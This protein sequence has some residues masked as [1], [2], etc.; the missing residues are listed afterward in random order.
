M[1]VRYLYQLPMEGL[2]ILCILLT[3]H[4]MSYVHHFILINTFKPVDSYLR[5]SFSI[6]VCAHNEL[7]NLKRLIPSILSQE[8]NDF[9]AIIILDRC[10]DNSLS[11]LENIQKNHS[12]LKVIEVHDLPKQYNGKKYGLSK[13]IKTATK[14]WIL[15]TDADCLPRSENWIRAFA[16]Q[17]SPE[18]EIILGV[19]PYNKRPGL[20]NHF[21]QYETLTTAIRYTG[22]AIRQ[23]PYM[24]VGRN[25]CFRKSLFTK[26]NGYEEHAS[27]MGGDDDLF[28]QKHATSTNTRVIIGKESLTYSV[29]KRTLKQY[30]RQKIRHLHVGKHYNKKQQFTHTL[31]ATIHL[32]LWLSFIYLAFIYSPWWGLICL[33]IMLMLMKGFIYTQTARKMGISYRPFLLPVTDFIYGMLYP[34]VGLKAH[35]T[36]KAK[37]S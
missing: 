17:T 30:M 10:T 7:E 3:V 9:E 23:H 5:P 11:Y 36:K 8:Y 34:L 26:S 12:N 22:E 35:F 14:E 29:P 25:L 32:M 6:V 28:V 18:I 24:G 15:L 27:I 21:I 16:S 13:G 1:G 31:S 20:L 4:L 37:W 19:S 2:I 33:F